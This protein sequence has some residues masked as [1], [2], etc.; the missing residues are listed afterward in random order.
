VNK[1]KF[2]VE[3]LKVVGHEIRELGFCKEY[4]QNF[5]FSFAAEEDMK[6][7]VNV[8]NGFSR[9]GDEVEMDMQPRSWKTGAIDK[10][11]ICKNVFRQLKLMFEQIKKDNEQL[12]YLKMSKATKD[13]FRIYYSYEVSYPPR[14]LSD[15]DREV[16]KI[17]GSM[18]G[19]KIVQ[20]E[21]VKQDVVIPI[22]RCKTIKSKIVRIC[23]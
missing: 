23:S 4:K 21:E 22:I 10:S 7:S 15:E 17:V 3:Q 6:I 1:F 2:L 20:S 16:G 9:I 5:V 8:V 19:V 18:M 11:E 12:I 14:E 13:K